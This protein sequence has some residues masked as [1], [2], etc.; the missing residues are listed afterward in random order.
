[1]E[2]CNRVRPEWCRPILAALA[3][4]SYM[5]ARAEHDIAAAQLYQLGDPEPGLHAEMKKGPIPPPVPRRQV[6]G[7][8][9]RLDLLAVEVIDHALLVALGRKG[10]YTLTMM[11]G[12]AVR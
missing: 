7:G 3:A 12:A 2:D 9:Q 6:G 8:E 5:G 10:E 11:Q 4:A 1:M